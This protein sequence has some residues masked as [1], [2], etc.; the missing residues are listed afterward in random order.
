KISPFEWIKPQAPSLDEL[1]L[2]PWFSGHLAVDGPERH[3]LGLVDFLSL[4][5]WLSDPLAMIVHPRKL[6]IAERIRNFTPLGTLVDSL[7]D[8]RIDTPYAMLPTLGL[9]FMLRGGW[10]A[11]KRFVE[12]IAEHAQRPVLQVGYVFN[13]H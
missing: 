3:L 7:R 4:I 11:C 12:L 1:A 13:S 10:T 5:N 8:Q 6:E 9:T 2:N